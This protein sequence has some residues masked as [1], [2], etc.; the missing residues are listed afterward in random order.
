MGGRCMQSQ[1][2]SNQEVRRVTPHSDRLLR[3]NHFVRITGLYA[4]DQVITAHL[5]EYGR[6]SCDHGYMIAVTSNGEIW[7]CVEPQA[8]DLAKRQNDC[9]R[10]VC[11]SGQGGP[12]F[13]ID[14]I[15]LRYIL[16]RSQ[17]QNC[18][19]DPRSSH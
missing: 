2:A 11:R 8:E 7:L 17:D 4:S 10:D 3:D 6:W 18:N 19:P 15:P 14:S 9:L 12:V 16:A 1:P 5:S 13:D